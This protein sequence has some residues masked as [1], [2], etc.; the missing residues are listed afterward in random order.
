M[1]ECSLKTGNVPKEWERADWYNAYLKNYENKENPLNYNPVSLTSIICKICEKV[2][3]KQRT[4]YL[5]R[6]KIIADRQFG[7]RT[8]GTCVTNL[9]RLLLKRNRYNTRK[10]W[11]AD[12][13]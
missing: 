7:F 11:W 13:M 3:K 9:L 8:E 2:I 4:E 6:D 1:I 5:K 12:C 10:M